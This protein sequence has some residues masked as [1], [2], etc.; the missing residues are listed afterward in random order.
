[1]TEQD[2]KPKS[3]RR[4]VRSINLSV[5][6]D[7]YKRLLIKIRHENLSWKRFFNMMIQGFLN[8]DQG[9]MDYIDF[10]MSELRAKTRTKKLQKERVKVQETIDVF[11]LDKDDISDIYDILEEE[12]DP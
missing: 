11:G 12:F 6:D 5:P 1:M 10:Q 8:D 4:G 7:T 2:E 9:V 3:Q